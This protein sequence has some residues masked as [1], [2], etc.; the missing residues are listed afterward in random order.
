M[1]LFLFREQLP[2]RTYKGHYSDYHRY[3]EYLASDLKNIVA[4]Q[5]I[6][7]SGFGG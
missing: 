6:Q 7:A 2:Q 1:K 4:I 5:L 3:K